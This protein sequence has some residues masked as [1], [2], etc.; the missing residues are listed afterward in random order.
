M[1]IYGQGRAVQDQ[2]KHA[3]AIAQFDKALGMQASASMHHRIG[4]SWQALN[5]KPGAIASDERALGFK[6]PLGKKQL[7]DA[8]DQ[9]KNL[10][11]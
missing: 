4:Q 10:K 8:Q 1:V 7:E 9:F 2:G 3:D 11:G 6:P 5:D